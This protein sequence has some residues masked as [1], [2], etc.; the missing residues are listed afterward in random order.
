MIWQ[1]QEAKSKFSQLVRQALSEGPQIVI[2]HGEEVA[3]VLSIDD[4]RRL[5]E[6]RPS[7]LELLLD[8]P[9]R[10]SGLEIER[11]QEDYGREAA[12]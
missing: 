3:V 9:L 2:R 6:P 1:L 7:L 12:L 11:D 4:Y 10:G 8:S 5:S